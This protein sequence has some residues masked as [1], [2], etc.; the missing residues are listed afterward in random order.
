MKPARIPPPPP[1]PTP[2]RALARL[3]ELGERQPAVVHSVD[4]SGARVGASAASHLAD[5]G[6][7]PGETVMVMARGWP[8]GDP[9]V[10]RVGVSTFALR[11]AEARCVSVVPE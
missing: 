7:I 6:F 2:P 10:V 3:D 4:A 11:R 9:L 5:I 1:T 8:G